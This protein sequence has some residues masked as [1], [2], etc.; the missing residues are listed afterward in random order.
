MF[1][2]KYL[3]GSGESPNKNSH[4]TVS[5]WSR[6]FSELQ[7]LLKSTRLRGGM[8]AKLNQRHPL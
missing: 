3:S 6:L 7:I 1:A 8:I 2:A 4:L 5:F